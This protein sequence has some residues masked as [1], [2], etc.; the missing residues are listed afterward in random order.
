MS[1][2]LPEYRLVRSRRR[3]LA[4]VID[5]DGTLTVRAPLKLAN[6]AIQE[7]LT[8]KADWVRKTQSKLKARATQRQSHI[9]ETGD[10]FLWLGQIFPLTLVPAQRPA[11]QFDRVRF[12]LSESAQ[13]NARRLFENWYREQARAH[14]QTRLDHFSRLHNL[15]YHGLR[16][17]AAR[18]RWGSCNSKN[19]LAFTWRLLMAPPEVVDYVVVHELAHT[20][21]HNH[22]PK[23]WKLVAD[24][25]PN[26][27]VH[28]H[29]LK[30]HGNKLHLE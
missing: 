1:S 22:G 3:T 4:L 16:I 23:F 9:F 19:E 25:L 29:W 5:A 11:L 26:F 28:V 6:S 7:F 14:L 8:Q 12:T 13:P 27:K 20:V 18:T 21:H 15:T 24:I 10:S 2:P 30:E 17:T